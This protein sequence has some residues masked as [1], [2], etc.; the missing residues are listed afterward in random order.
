MRKKSRFQLILHIARSGI[1]SQSD[2]I[3]IFHHISHA[4]QE[5]EKKNNQIQ[6][7]PSLF[8]K[9]RR[10]K[11]PR[12]T[13]KAKQILKSKF[14]Q[15]HSPFPGKEEGKNGEKRNDPSREN[16]RGS[17]RD[18]FAADKK[19]RMAENRRSYVI[20]GT[21]VSRGIFFQRFPPKERHEGKPATSRSKLPRIVATPL[22]ISPKEDPRSTRRNHE[23]RSAMRNNG[24]QG[25][26]GQR[27]VPF[28]TIS[29]QDIDANSFVHGFDE[30]RG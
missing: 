26:Q 1:S 9:E 3:I 8:L 13:S 16:E 29:L 6:N 5:E 25:M 21:L 7:I 10:K 23:W 28:F 11:S 18:R 22:F 24:I 14:N 20:F 17:R 4:S 30:E 2:S 12:H 15:G 27:G 19:R